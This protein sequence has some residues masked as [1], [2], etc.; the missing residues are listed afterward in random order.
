MYVIQILYR[1]EIVRV[2]AISESATLT[3]LETSNQTAL[4]ASVKTSNGSSAE[5]G[6][7]LRQSA[8]SRRIVSTTV[9]EVWEM[10]SRP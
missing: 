2:A 4:A 7:W 1:K 10:E 8:P 6:D 5:S 3:H 9:W